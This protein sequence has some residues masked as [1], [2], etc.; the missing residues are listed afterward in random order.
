MKA[1]LKFLSLNKLNYLDNSNTFVYNYLRREK[2]ACTTK[3]KW[4]VNL[5]ENGRNWIFTCLDIQDEWDEDSED[6]EE[7]KESDP[8]D[9]DV[10]T[11]KSV[12]DS[13]DDSGAVKQPVDSADIAADNT[14]NSTNNSDKSVDKSENNGSP[15]TNLETTAV[16]EN[17]TKV[18]Q[19]LNDI[20]EAVAVDNSNSVEAATEDEKS[21]DGDETKSEL[22]DQDLTVLKKVDG[23]AD[24]NSAENL[25]DNNSWEGKVVDNG[26]SQDNIAQVDGLDDLEVSFSDL[27]CHS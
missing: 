16:A 19:T 25:T 8:T 11:D 24:N 15:T 13:A 9:A 21:C 4:R 10:P 5:L 27:Y 2:Y 7:E 12:K 23:A 20:T 17:I 1:L 6:G 14:D 22:T 3:N 18:G 26:A